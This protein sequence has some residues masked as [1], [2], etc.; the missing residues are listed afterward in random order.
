MRC[1]AGDIAFVNSRCVIPLAH[2]KV[3]KCV[4]VVYSRRGVPTWL[5]DPPISATHRA[6]ITD[7]AGLVIPAGHPFRL[8]SLDDDWL[9][10]IR[11]QPGEDETLQWVGLPADPVVVER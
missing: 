8:L 6:T 5:V 7:G 4:E 11:D 1:R 2:D 10:P 9:T 3:V